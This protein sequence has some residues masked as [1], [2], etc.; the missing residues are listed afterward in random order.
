M[1]KKRNIHGLFG[2][3]DGKRSFR[4]PTRRWKNNIHIYTNEAE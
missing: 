1:V 2:K 3:L 4:R